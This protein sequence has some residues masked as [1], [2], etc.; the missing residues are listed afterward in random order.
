MKKIITCLIIALL[1]CC[2]NTYAQHIIVDYNIET[3]SLFNEEKDFEGIAKEKSKEIIEGFNRSLKLLNS[4]KAHLIASKSESY[5]WFENTMPSD[6]NI[7]DYDMAKIMIGYG[8]SYYSNQLSGNYTHFFS[9][10]GIKFKIKTPVDSLIWKLSKETKIIGDLKCFK[11]TTSYKVKNN[12]REHTVEVIA[13]YDPSLQYNFGPK[14]FSGL[15]GLIIELKDDKITY[16]VDTIKFKESKMKTIKKPN[17]KL[18]TK[19]ELEEYGE[20]A[21]QNFNINRN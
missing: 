16:S 6:I 8:D 15:P 12:L 3:N 18:I 21:Q 1:F 20:K 7:M 11:A 19:E 2:K 10:Y 4:M 9:A 5:F 13:W 14:G 17:G